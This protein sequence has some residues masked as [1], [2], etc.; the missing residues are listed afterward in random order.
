[1]FWTLEKTAPSVSN[2]R[3]SLRV[4]RLRSALNTSKRPSTRSSAF[5][6]LMASTAP[7]ISPM[8]PVTPPV[9]SRLAFRYRWT[10]PRAMLTMTTTAATG[11]KTPNVISGSIRAM[12][13]SAV[14]RNIMCATKN[15]N[16]EM[17][18]AT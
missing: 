18:S 3:V 7:N 15:L 13:N 11:T 16:C 14:G 2:S 17:Y 12:M 5:A 10:R 6:T 1:M 4:V 8:K 9:A